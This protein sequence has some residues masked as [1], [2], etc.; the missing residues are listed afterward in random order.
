VSFVTI[1]IPYK[2]NLKYLFFTLKSIFAQTYKKYKILIIYDDDDKTDLQRLKKY[3]SKNKKNKKYS[4]NIII[5][6]KNLGPGQSR[7]IG[8]LNSNTKY[9]AFLDSD[10]TW[11]KD[12]LKK[13]I[14]F[15][16]KK[17]LVISHT[18]YVVVDSQDKKISNRVAKNKIYLKDLIKSC[19]IG[20]ST[21]ISDVKFLKKNNFYFPKNI[22][23]KEDYV[24]WLNI[25]KKINVIWG[26]NINLMNYRKTKNSLSS[27]ISLN[28]LNGY[29]VYRNYMHYSILKSFYS[30]LCLSINYLKK[31]YK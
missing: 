18:S 30:L 16:K 29:R 21:V 25:I 15:M 12:K 17:D 2:N 23:T 6:K 4:I 19:D 11:H 7:N 10:D 3:I 26:I 9:V 13:Q 14:L 1:I 24:L 5:N 8:I 31:T 27:N 20:L 22:K 28:L